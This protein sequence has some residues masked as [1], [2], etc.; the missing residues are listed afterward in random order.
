MKIHLDQVFSIKDLGRLSY[1]LGIEVGYLPNGI[2]LTQKKFTNELLQSA[3]ITTFKRVVTPL[4]VNLK[5]EANEGDIFPDVGLYRCLVG[6]LNFLT[7][8]RPD[9]AYIVQHLSQ[10]LQQPRIPHYQA[11]LHSLH[12]VSSTAGQ[13]I[14]LRTDEQLT[15]QAFSDSDWGACMDSRRYI[16][17]YVM[18]LGKSPISWKSNKQGIVSRSS[19]E[20]EYRSMSNA[21]SEVTWLVR[22]L[23]EL[24]VTNLKLVTL[25]C[26]NQS[27]IH[28]ARNPVH[29]ER[30]KHI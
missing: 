4:P 14:L 23:E 12:Y 27:A 5:L 16:S 9:L 22:L 1:F 13:G 10:F 2:T 11:L 3:G 19:S 20:A 29:H 7:H 18:L 15:L 26:D 6:K 30:T 25:Y 8:T 24:G 21:A 17:G 28:I